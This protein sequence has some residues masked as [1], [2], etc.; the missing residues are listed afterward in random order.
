IPA[1]PEHV[2]R[3]VAGAAA[4]TVEMAAGPGGAGPV[5]YPPHLS[6]AQ[7]EDLHIRRVISDVGGNLSQAARVLGISRTTLWRKM[8]RYG[9]SAAS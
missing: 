3:S 9:I 7:V 6:L 4:N 5:A 2:E 8:K 1:L